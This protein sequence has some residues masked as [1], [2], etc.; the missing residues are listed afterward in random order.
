MRIKIKTALI[1]LK[2]ILLLPFSIYPT[3][4][5]TKPVRIIPSTIIKY[6]Q[7]STS[8]HRNS[9]INKQRK[10]LKKRIA[11]GKN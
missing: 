4:E 1:I 6:I 9:R 8:N 3:Y 7:K 5:E 10:V 11:Y 2:A